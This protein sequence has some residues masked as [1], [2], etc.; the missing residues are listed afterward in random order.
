LEGFTY[1]TALDLSMG[2][3]YIPLSE[4]VQALCTTV[5]PLGKI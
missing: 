5:S 4:S 2:Y 1:A 3:Y